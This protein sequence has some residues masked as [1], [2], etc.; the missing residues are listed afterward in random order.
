MPLSRPM[1]A[2]RGRTKTI[3]Q[4]KAQLDGSQEKA[5]AFA[6]ELETIRKRQ[7][8]A[9]EEIAEAEV[10]LHAAEQAKTSLLAELQRSE[11]VDGA[12]DVKAAVAAASALASSLET[13]PAGTDEQWASLGLTVGRAEFTAM[14]RKVQQLATEPGASPG[15]GGLQGG[16]AGSQDLVPPPGDGGVGGPGRSGGREPPGDSNHE[17]EV[18]ICTAGLAEMEPDKL[19]R[20]GLAERVVNGLTKR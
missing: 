5:E 20:R 19:K 14:L 13:P 6:K 10:A 12:A 2:L 1:C 11:A 4:C 7:A 9:A 3:R 15:V 16:G 18:D 8:A 17:Q